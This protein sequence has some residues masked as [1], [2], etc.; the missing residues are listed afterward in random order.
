MNTGDYFNIQNQQ[1]RNEEDNR[2][3]E[4]EKHYRKALKNKEFILTPFW[5]LDQSEIDFTR[6]LND[7]PK[8]LQ[9]NSAYSI[10]HIEVEELFRIATKRLKSVFDKK[11]FWKA[12][13]NDKIVD[14]LEKWESG[15]KLI[16][17]IINSY[18]FSIN[19]QDGN[20]RFSVCCYFDVMTIPIIVAEEFKTVFLLK[21]N[22]DKITLV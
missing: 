17:V 13:N 14:I 20:H 1:Q 15:E 7:Y 12:R 2:F 5:H 16:P 8:F 3:R 4:L 10:Y 22:P 6:L 11:K 21:A 9:K 19:I 18:G